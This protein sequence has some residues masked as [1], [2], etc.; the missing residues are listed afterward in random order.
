MVHR[1]DPTGSFTGDVAIQAH[2][3]VPFKVLK[4]VMFS[5]NQ[6]GYRNVSFAVLGGASST[7]ALTN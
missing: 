2:K 3:E 6:A 4:R 7:R 5:C 1:D